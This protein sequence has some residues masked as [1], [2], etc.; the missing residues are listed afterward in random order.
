MIRVSRVVGPAVLLLVAF[1]ALL[2]SLAYGGGATAPAAINPGAAR[3]LR[4]ADREP[5][6]HPE[7]FRPGRLAAAGRVRV[8]V[9]QARVRHAR[10]MSH[11]HPPPI[12]TVSSA[13]TT[14]F[15]LQTVYPEPVEFDSQFGATLWTLPHR[16]SARAG[17]ARDDPHRRGRS[18][19]CSSSCA[20]RPPSR[21]LTIGRDPFAHPDGAAGPLRRHREPQRG[22]DID[23]PAHC[24]CGDLA[25]WAAH[26]RPVSQAARGRSDR[27]GDRALLDARAHLLRR[28]RDLGRRERGDP[29]RAAART[30]SRR[31]A[32]WCSSRSSRSARSGSS[33]SS[34]AAS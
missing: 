34:S 25:R 18:R 11:P 31:T 3:A 13:A 17:L 22:D 19:S 27:D 23:L 32:S 20:T 33:A 4:P 6:R 16:Q 5:P 28:R 21:C 14:F 10:W 26:A 12:L 24:L 8:L 15:N 7:R 30:C 9:D 1:A 29:H 2:A